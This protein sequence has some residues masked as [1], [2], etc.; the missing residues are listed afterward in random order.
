MTSVSRTF[1]TAKE[2]LT[3]FM[4][5]ESVSFYDETDDTDR[6]FPFICSNGLLDITYEGNNFQAQMV[7]VSGNSPDD[8]TN[9][10]CRIIGAPRLVTSLG[11][12]F[13]AYIR[14]WRYDTIDTG[15]PIELVEP[16]QVVRVQE[17]NRNNLNGSSESSYRISDKKPASDNYITGNTANAYR[18]SFIFKTPLTFSIVESGVTQYITFKTITEQEG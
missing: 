6:L 5:V 8:E 13:K 1:G 15:S 10:L 11:D 16:S 4:R 12:N 18:T 3:K 9:N 2:G 17:G 14:A 7:D